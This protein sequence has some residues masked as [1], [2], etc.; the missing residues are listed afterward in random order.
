M[1]IYM[2]IY[3]HIYL[4]IY[5]YVYVYIGIHIM[6]R[7]TQNALSFH[8]DISQ[9]ANVTIPLQSRSKTTHLEITLVDIYRLR[10]CLYV[11]MTL[12]DA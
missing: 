7:I 5:I 11:A 2:Y 8:G 1:Y 4:H 12:N 6:I 10:L 9:N 3:T